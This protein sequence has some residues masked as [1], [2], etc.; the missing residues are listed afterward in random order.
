M[1]PVNTTAVGVARRSACFI[2]IVAYVWLR[3]WGPPSNA[4][5]ADDSYRA[6][7]VGGSMEKSPNYRPCQTSRAF[8][9]ERAMAD[10]CFPSIAGERFGRLT[11]AAA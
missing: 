11:M 3:G 8:V 5:K 1:V 10:V 7:P 2:G 6:M 9:K 4:E